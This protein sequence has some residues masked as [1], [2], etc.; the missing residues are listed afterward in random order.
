MPDS[1]KKK[2]L[3]VDDEWSMRNLLKDILELFDFE[4]SI[5]KNAGEFRTRVFNDSPHLIILDILLGDEEGTQVYA[6]LLATGL[7][8][9]IPV[10]FLSALSEDRLPDFSSRGKNCIFIS[11]PFAPDKLV[12][13]IKRLVLI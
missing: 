9:K 3:V 10:I 8:E 13:Q 4:V 2:I 5:A 7:D 11:K 1:G 6:D 12:A